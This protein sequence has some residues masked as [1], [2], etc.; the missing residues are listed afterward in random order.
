[1]IVD[2][3]EILVVVVVAGNPVDAGNPRSDPNALLN[4]NF[5]VLL[6]IDGTATAFAGAVNPKDVRCA[7]VGTGKKVNCALY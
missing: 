4:D 2:T 5:G 1:V 3:R 7:D 6:A